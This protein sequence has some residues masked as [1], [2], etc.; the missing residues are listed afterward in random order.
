MPGRAPPEPRLLERVEVVGAHAARHTRLALELG[1]VDAGLVLDDLVDPAAHE[2]REEPLARLAVDEGA[3][4]PREEEVEPDFRAAEEEAGGAQAG[5]GEEEQPRS[6]AGG[7]LG[8]G[9]RLH[10]HG[11]GGR[12]DARGSG[13]GEG[14]GVVTGVKDHAFE[15]GADGHKLAADTPPDTRLVRG[16]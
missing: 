14:H 1:E 2:V 16:P 8:R 13:G 11:A 9:P 12:G 6:R 15:R 3:K 5:E 7:E 10:A 4:E